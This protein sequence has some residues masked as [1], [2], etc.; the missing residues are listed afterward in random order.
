MIPLLQMGKLRFGEGK[1]LPRLPNR[2]R[3]WVSVSTA[4]LLNNHKRLSLLKG[5][6]GIP[7]PRNVCCGRREEKLLLLELNDHYPLQAKID[8]QSNSLKT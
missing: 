5:K 3:A 2:W 8:Y 1:H 4:C 7:L 6:E